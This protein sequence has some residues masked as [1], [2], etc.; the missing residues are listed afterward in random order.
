MIKLTQSTA[1]SLPVMLID[2][3]D[4]VAPKTGIVEGSVTVVTSKDGGA[5]TGFTLTD[6]WTE[7]GQG[8]Y[9]IDFSSSS[10]CPIIALIFVLYCTMSRTP[11]DASWR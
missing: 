2:S 11:R 1:R 9:T 8:L 6:K 3:D 4:H 5:L 10:I 7:L